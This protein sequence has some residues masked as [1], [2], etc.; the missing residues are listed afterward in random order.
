[1]FCHCE[2]VALIQKVYDDLKPKVLTAEELMQQPRPGLVPVD[3][4]EFPWEAKRKQEEAA[5]AAAAEAAGG[6]G[7]GEAGQ[8]P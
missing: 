1:M 6:Q 7:G 5:A 8:K 3:D 4:V 2:Q